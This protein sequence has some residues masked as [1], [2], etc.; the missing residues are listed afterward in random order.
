MEI[1]Y[2]CGDL[3]RVNLQYLSWQFFVIHWK[4]L[5]RIF[6]AVFI[7]SDIVR[8]VARRGRVLRPSRD[9][10]MGGQMNILNGSLNY[11]TK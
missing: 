11:G 3:K 10:K 2:N 5:L 1:W 4:A 9:G 6:T 8:D 7:L